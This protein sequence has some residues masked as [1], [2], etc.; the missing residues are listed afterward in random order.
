MVY[1]FNCFH[2]LK[3]YS[4][5]RDI[6]QC[7]NEQKQEASKYLMKINIYYGY[8]GYHGIYNTP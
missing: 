4:F 2:R 8:H 1:L 7:I 3:K 5:W 6:T